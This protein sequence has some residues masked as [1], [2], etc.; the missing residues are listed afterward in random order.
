MVL[1]HSIDAGSVVGVVKAYL[2]AKKSEL[3]ALTGDGDAKILGAR[4]R[5][6]RP[7]LVNKEF[8]GLVIPVINFGNCFV[9]LYQFT[10]MTWGKLTK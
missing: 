7:C 8:Y 9:L 5:V 6:T 1:C 4:A 10:Y 3:F 2:Y